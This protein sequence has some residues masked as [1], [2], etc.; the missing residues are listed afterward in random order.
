MRDLAAVLYRR[1]WLIAAVTIA[2]I[3]LSA[4]YTYTRT[5]V[6]TSSVGILVRPPTSLTSIARPPD[7][8]SQTETN[9]ATSAAVASLASELMASPETDAA[10]LKD[11]TANMV[12]G[13]QFLTITFSAADAAAAKQGAQ[14]FGD[15]YLQYRR[16]R[17]GRSSS[18]RRRFSPSSCRRSARGSGRSRHS[19]GTCRQ[20][21]SS[22]PP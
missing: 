11:V 6:Y 19:C 2:M 15:A 1:R 3:G 12:T 21:R 16:E 22:E 4:F 13:T 10:L 5:P 7:I 9:L 20:G 14:A 18:N 8:D 17:A